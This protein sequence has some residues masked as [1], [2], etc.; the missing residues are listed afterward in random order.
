M[1]YLLAFIVVIFLFWEGFRLL[2]TIER[3]DS[4]IKS[5]MNEIGY[6]HFQVQELRNHIEEIRKG[7]D[8]E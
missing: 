8:K 1:F 2:D 7:G 3:K 6:L 4:L 5:Q